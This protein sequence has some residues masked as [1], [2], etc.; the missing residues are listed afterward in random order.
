VTAERCT[1]R[2]AAAGGYQF[3]RCERLAFDE[4]LCKMHLSAKRKRDANT[5]RKM[6]ERESR[7][8]LQDAQVAALDAAKDLAAHLDEVGVHG[9]GESYL[10]AVRSTVRV[11][12]AA[13]ERS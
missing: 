9:A 5:A 10:N 8:A 11:L 6:A 1:E 13:E 12:L 7:H 3:H 4:G 2:V